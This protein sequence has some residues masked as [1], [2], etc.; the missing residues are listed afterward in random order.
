M[1]GLIQAKSIPTR[2]IPARLHILGLLIDHC[3]YTYG[4]LSNSLIITISR[5]EKGAMPKEWQE[6]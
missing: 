4:R 6:P 3:I 1:E 5:S 2:T